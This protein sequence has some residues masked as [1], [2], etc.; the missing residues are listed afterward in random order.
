MAQFDSQEYS[1]NS[2]F[3]G[4]IGGLS[5]G[6]PNINILLQV[7]FDYSMFFIIFHTNKYTNL[8]EEEEAEISGQVSPQK[9]Q[10][11]TNLQNSENDSQLDTL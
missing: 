2:P 8:T 9:K 4:H 1:I 5:F 11:S 7:C 3:C 6:F 10:I